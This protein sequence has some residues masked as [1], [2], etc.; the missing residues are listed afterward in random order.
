MTRIANLG[1]VFVAVLGLV[2]LIPMAAQADSVD[3]NNFSFELDG[4]DNQI[5]GH[6]VAG[7]PEW[8]ITLK[9]WTV[10]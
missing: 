5:L 6:M 4:N 2:G 1:L 7:H 9:G 3:V 8:G 10:S